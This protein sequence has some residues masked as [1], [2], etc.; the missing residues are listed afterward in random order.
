M[1]LKFLKVRKL[2]ILSMYNFVLRTSLLQSYNVFDEL[3]DT[4]QET[5]TIKNS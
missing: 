5:I 4:Q 3:K 2:L 1:R